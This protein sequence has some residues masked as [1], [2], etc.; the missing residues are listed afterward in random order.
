MNILLFGKNGQL[1]S[2]FQRILP[3][4]GKTA[5]LDYQDLDLCDLHALKQVMNDLKPNLIVNASA[6]TAVDRAE[7]EQDTAMKVNALAPGAMAEWARKNGAVLIHYSTDYVFDGRKGAPYTEN[8]PANPLNVYG[9]SKLGGEENIQQA[10]GA[11]LILRTSWV[12]S[13]GGAGFV[14]KILE[15]SRKNQTLKIV[16][17]Q[18]S[19]PTW[20]RDLAEA[21]FSVIS[22][23]RD[24]LQEV[25]QERRGIYHL[26]GG[27]YASRYEWARQILANDPK[28][29]EQLVQTLEPASS[30]E[31]PLPAARPPF[32]ALDCSKFKE[33]FGFSLPDWRE[34][35][36]R[37]MAE[38]Q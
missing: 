11:Y 33:A 31:F 14:S 28:R 3:K 24:H 4:L 26:A 18:I 12:Y 13:A 20:A 9:R 35:L 36:R 1:G 22:A 30:E 8:D 25:M 6:Y 10:G 17:D 21:T 7:T 16:S 34:S 15:W 27:G 37:A 23:H 2:E 5:F 19:N 29:T 38:Q 32:S